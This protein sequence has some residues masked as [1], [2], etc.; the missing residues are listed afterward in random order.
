MKRT[1]PYL[2]LLAVFGVVGL[3]SG[4]AQEG[5]YHGAGAEDGVQHHAPAQGTHR[6]GTGLV[7]GELPKV[8]SEVRR[9]NTRANTIS[10]RHGQI[11]NLDM[12]PMTM[13]FQVSDPSLL[14]G[15]AAGDEILATFDQIDGAYTLLSVEPKP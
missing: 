10:L 8:E 1:L 15:L 9:I 6:S 5:R 13:V 14:E 2:T 12:P 4:H 3:N 7:Q 11:P